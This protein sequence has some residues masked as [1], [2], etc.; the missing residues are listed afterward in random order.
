MKTAFLMAAACLLLAACAGGGG[1]DNSKVRI[2]DGP[3][4][5][6]PGDPVNGPMTDGEIRSAFGGKTFQYTKPAGNGIMTFNA[7]GTTEIQDD[8]RG[9]LTGS[10]RASDGALCEAL[11]PGP[12]LPEGAP[13]TCQKAN[14]SGDAI[15]AGKDRFAGV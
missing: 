5:T 15:Y 3:G 6:R 4:G 13:E 10:W 9:S 14:N 1:G 7:D 12:S 11:N 2:T 8:T